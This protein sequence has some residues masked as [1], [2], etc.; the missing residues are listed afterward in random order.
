MASNPIDELPSFFRLNQEFEMLICRLHGAYTR[1]SYKRHLLE[2]HK[3]KDESLKRYSEIIEKARLKESRDMVDRPINGRSPIEGLKIKTGYGC[4]QCNSL[5]INKSWMKKHL[6]KHRNLNLIRSGY[7]TGVQF[8]SLWVKYPQY[9][10]VNLPPTNPG[11]L[12]E[13]ESILIPNHTLDTLKVQYDDSQKAR[14]RKYQHL[15]EP[16]HVSENTP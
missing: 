5:T 8:Q 12:P 6:R 14:K 15:N 4:S 2:I 9:F 13:T 3:I 1:S 10:Q 11:P 7:Q 16:I